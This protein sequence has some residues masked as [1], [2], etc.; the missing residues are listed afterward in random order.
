MRVDASGLTYS[1]NAMGNAF[2]DVFFQ[3]LA[4]TTIQPVCIASSS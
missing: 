4:R 3:R 1:I 2:D